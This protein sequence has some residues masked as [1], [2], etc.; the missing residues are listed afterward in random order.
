MERKLLIAASLAFML[1]SHPVWALQLTNN[2]PTEQKIAITEKSN[3]RDLVIK[4]S[5][6]LKD[7]CPEGCTM[8]MSD[9]E[10]YEFDG[11]EVVF[12][13]EG[14]MFLDDEAQGAAEEPAEDTG[15]TDQ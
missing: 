7:L 15:S 13:E 8:R 12:V 2:D 9:G 5:E 4:P 1:S 11:D 3:S 14:L 6:T 10:E